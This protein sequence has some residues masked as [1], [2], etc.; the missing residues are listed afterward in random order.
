[1]FSPKLSSS[2]H[3]IPP[4]A[5][6]CRIFF[7]ETCRTFRL[8]PGESLYAF[9]ITQELSLEHLYFGPALHP[10]FDL[11]YLSSSSRRTHFETS[12]MY[13]KT[14]HA[15]SM[16]RSNQMIE[17]DEILFQM[18]PATVEDLQEIWRRNRVT[19]GTSP[20]SATMDTLESFERR[21]R[22]NFA[23]RMMSL[24]SKQ[25]NKLKTNF[26]PSPI[27]TTKSSPLGPPASSPTFTTP[28][29]QHHEHQQRVKLPPYNREGISSLDSVI[30][31]PPITSQ[32][33]NEPPSPP[34]PLHRSVSSAS[35]IGKPAPIDIPSFFALTESPQGSPRPTLPES[36]FERLKSSDFAKGSRKVIFDRRGGK[37]G[38]GSI[39][40]EYSDLGTGDFRS[41]SFV[42]VDTYNGS[43]IS[44]LR[45]RRHEIMKG[46][47]NPKGLPCF[48]RRSAGSDDSEDGNDCMT[49][50][51]TMGD[52]GSGLEVDL[53]YSVFNDYDAVIR[54]T[55]FRNL[56]YR[57]EPTTGKARAGKIIQRAMSI[58]NDFEGES[59]S[60]YCVKLCGSWGRERHV[61]SNQLTHGI[62]SFSSTRGV[63]GHQH[64]P[65]VA[66]TIGP[67][68][69]TSGEVK[70]WN[71]VYSGN[72]MT[73]LQLND[74][75]RL[76]VNVGI[77]PEC[78]QW[79]LKDKEFTT[80]ECVLVRSSEGLGGMSRCMHRLIRD[81]LMPRCK[82]AIENPP[83]LINTWEAYYFDIDYEKVMRL[84]RHAR[85]IGVDLLV[86][87]DG[88][89]LGR[90][91]D[92]RS[93]GNW[94][95]DPTKFPSLCKLS[96]DLKA[97]G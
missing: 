17:S 85:K 6:E 41:P 83:I 18:A 50:V 29:E 39:C 19:S 24:R 23:W 30:T 55:V 53:I 15:Q 4:V 52:L 8:Y 35:F 79:Y 9:S 45:Y 16:K 92:R 69:E 61:V 87:D 93:L 44:P 97:I 57:E 89:F 59:N 67:P 21:R 82:W 1:M 86:L 31:T 66:L 74:L 54:R 72:Y 20:L 11:R 28:L 43:S 42:V 2:P 40:S 75:G 34:P 94:V 3:G 48:R 38:K 63:S 68:S 95:A 7:D 22:D 88:W 60:F 14:I 58:T 10:G 64:S 36:S 49:L 96:Q 70:A 65:F 47:L 91:D 56:D 33:E 26:A 51:V 5:G 46:K 73:E 77:N 71:L 27:S 90:T 81:K 25:Q 37:I 80:P 12:E 78:W 13:E 32:K 62:T 84:A 76:R